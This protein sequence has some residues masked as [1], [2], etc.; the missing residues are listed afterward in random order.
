MSNKKIV[1]LGAG[2]AGLSAAWHLQK[3]KI[4]CS[5]FEKE[6]AVGGLCRSK[7]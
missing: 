7:K 2:L 4:E 6:P 3:K 5:V 1:I